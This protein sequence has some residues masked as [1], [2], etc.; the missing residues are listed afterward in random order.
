MDVI[1]L[2]KVEHLG[3]LGDRVKVKPGFARN[4][5]LPQGKATEATAA[6]IEAFESRRSELEKAAEQSK[7]AAQA[8]LAELKGVT[9]AITAKVGT[10]GRL[11]GSVGPA[12]LVAAAARLG[13][14]LRKSQI[15]M[16]DLIRQTGDYEVDLH[17]HTEVD[18]VVKV[19]VIAAE[20]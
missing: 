17:L 3:A 11:F 1:L 8:A 4:Y 5:L 6:N 9:L 13:V 10:E 2:E 14:T 20:S 16:A 15:R 18:G 7:A 12:D 19:E